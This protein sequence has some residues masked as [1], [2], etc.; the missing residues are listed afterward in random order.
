MSIE[1]LKP[2]IEG[3]LKDCRDISDLM[4][5][6]QKLINS[7]SICF[8]QVER[9]YIAKKVIEVRKKIQKVIENENL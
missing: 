9:D 6:E 3:H 5:L 7:F 1:S 2:L 4:I 8:G